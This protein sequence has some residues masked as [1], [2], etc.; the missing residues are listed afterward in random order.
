MNEEIKNQE[1][2]KQEVVEEA[3]KVASIDVEVISAKQTDTPIKKTH[4]KRKHQESEEKPSAIKEALLFFKDLAISLA[5]VLI[6]INFVIKPI[7]VRGQSMYPTLDTGE[8]G[9]SNLFGRKF[10]TI[11]RFDIVII[12][13]EDKDEYLVKRCVGLPGETISYKDNILSIIK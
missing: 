12:Y 9:V 13:L 11:N 1:R 3:N 4:H 7:Q 10:S 8:L 6:L 2:N 5:I